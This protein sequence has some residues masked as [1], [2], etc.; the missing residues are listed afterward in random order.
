MRI[1]QLCI[2]RPVFAIVINLILLIVGYIG[3]DRLNV[4]ELPR[5]EQFN[6]EIGTTYTGASAELIE[7]QITIPIEDMIAGVEGVEVIASKSRQGKSSIVI[8]FVADYNINEGMNDLR[9]QLSRVRKT[10]PDD[11]DDPILS[12]ADPNAAPT[13]YV[14]FSDTKRDALALTDYVDRYI[15]TELQQVEGVGNVFLYGA[16]EY[17]VRIWPD[18]LRMGARQVTVGDIEEVL[19]E[20]NQA[21]PSGYIKSRYRNFVID[22][23]TKLTHVD[24]FKSLVLKDTGGKMV[25][26]SDVADVEVGPLDEDNMVRVNG[27]P[28]VVIAIV[29]QTTANPVDVSD[30]VRARLVGFEKSMPE[31]MSLSVSYDS[32]TFIRA[33]IE[34]VYKTIYE[35]VLLVVLVVFAFLG[36]LRSS[37]IPV[38]TIPLCLIA[39]FG[40]IYLMG[41]TINTMT[42]LAMVLAIGL[43]VDDAIVML[44]NV[45]RHREH[46][47]AAIPAAKK[48][49]HEIGFAIIAMTLTLAAVYAPIGFTPGFT[50][51][52][53]REFAFTLAGA[54][55]VSG[56]VAL[57]LSPMMCAYALPATLETN[58]YTVWLEGFMHRLDNRYR[59][60]ITF[61]LQRRLIVVG[62][63]VGVAIL[64][65]LLL[66]SMKSELAPTEDTGT[67]YTIVTA[68]TNSSFRYLDEIMLSVQNVLMPIPERRNLVVVSGTGSTES[69]VAFLALTPWEDRSRTQAEITRSIQPKY[70][71]IPGAQIFAIDLPPVRGSGGGNNPVDIVVQMSG[72]YEELAQ[73]MQNFQNGLAKYAGVNSVQ[74]DL[75]MDSQQIEIKINRDLMSNLGIAF[76]ELNDALNI[77]FAGRHI[78]DFESNGENYD[79]MVQLKED[80]RANPDQINQ[81]YLRTADDHMVPLSAIVTLVPTVK[82]NTLPHYNRMR[83]ARLT[84]NLSPGYALSDA[85]EV[86]DEVA[87][88]VLPVNAKTSWA[89]FTKDYLQSSGA[90]LTTVILSLVFIYLVL[91]AQFESFTDPFIIMLTVPFSI[92]GAVLFLTLAGGTNNIYTQIGFVTLIGLITKH[93]IL[94]TDFA[95]KLADEGK[96]KYEAVVEAAVTRLRPILMTTGAMVL[97]AV[98]LALASGAGAVSRS[99]MGWVIVGGMLFGT[100]FSLFVVPVAY[101]FISRK[102]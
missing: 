7:S 96:N 72:T 26:M 90:M 78:T 32:A 64:G 79:V 59:T 15:K 20:Q 53:F 76:S 38:V 12:K 84:A 92:I 98:P 94:I 1:S 95:N 46:G 61:L 51:A 77:L 42:L 69:G 10:L 73:V 87:K 82:P 22:P 35:A 4:R 91:S 19:L 48:G 39:T 71:G 13:L 74:V 102:Q 75:K 2:D 81:I 14:S 21:L 3:F 97:G 49:S 24:E 6:V 30:G 100:L 37:I 52:I 89:G 18:P 68:P 88:T 67:I 63:F 34:E 47:E 66:T 50:G 58:R 62:F 31:G 9:D 43:V 56:F 99:Q 55:I 41:Y 36:S 11:A 29:P 8:T 40:L 80:L 28:S 57:T 93:G 54:V 27:K 85:V 101:T 86:V 45:F 83:A 60:A 5:T 44:E 17:S 23:D 16:R 70:F 33:S 25:R 65:G